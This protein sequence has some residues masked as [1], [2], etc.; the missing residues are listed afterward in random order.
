VSFPIALFLCD[1]KEQRHFKRSASSLL[2]MEL[3]NL[4]NAMQMLNMEFILEIQRL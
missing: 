4:N 2:T 3:A 1:T